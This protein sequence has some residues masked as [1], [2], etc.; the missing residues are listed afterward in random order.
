MKQKTI[1]YIPVG[2]TFALTTKGSLK[3]ILPLG[4]EAAIS[5]D[6][7]GKFSLSQIDLL[8]RHLVKNEA[9]NVLRFSILPVDTVKNLE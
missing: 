8:H 1:L 9:A 3:K 7:D 5:S 2:A 6:A 4:S